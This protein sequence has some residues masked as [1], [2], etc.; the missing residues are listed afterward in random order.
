MARSRQLSVYHLTVCWRHVIIK[1]SE[2][3][4]S[5]ATGSIQSQQFPTV[6]EKRELLS[7]VG[8]D[9]TCPPVSGFSG[10]LDSSRPG[11]SVGPKPFR[12]A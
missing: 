10:L 5:E 6:L 8:S 12:E 1:I 2:G 9:S 3:L 4:Q 7:K 11:N